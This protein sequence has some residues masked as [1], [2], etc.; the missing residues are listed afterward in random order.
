MTTYTYDR[1]GVITAIHEPGGPTT[2]SVD[3][4]SRCPTRE[5]DAGGLSLPTFVID[6]WGRLIAVMDASG[7]E[8]RFD[9]VRD[10]PQPAPDLA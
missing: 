1:G 6:A 4:D 2:T 8:T 7:A 9:A 3:E 5:T 10:R